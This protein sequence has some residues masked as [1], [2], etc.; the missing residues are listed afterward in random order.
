MIDFTPFGWFARFLA[1]DPTLAMVGMTA[2]G[3]VGSGAKS[4]S[5]PELG[6]D[7]IDEAIARVQAAIGEF[8]EG[9]PGA[10]LDVCSHRADATLFGGWGGHER[11]WDELDPRYRWAAARFTGGEVA[12][13]ELSRFVSAGLAATVHH[14]RMRA[15]LAG[16]N[17]RASI[18]LRVTHI[19]RQ[20]E[21]GWKLVHRHA[22]PLIEILPPQSV[23]ER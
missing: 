3:A 22:D 23:V 12:F 14:E 9:R 2:M 4:T 16:S 21:T 6:D 13:T 1:G 19:Y 17:G 15:R 18:V 8:V 11:G 5:S 20:E 7:T 10:W